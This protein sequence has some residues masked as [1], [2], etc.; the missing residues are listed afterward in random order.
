MPDLDLPEALEL[1]L[2]T[3]EPYWYFLGGRPSI[4]LVNTFRER[5]R[6]RVE[7]LVTPG[8]LAAWLRRAGLL[9]PAATPPRGPRGHA[10]LADARA[11]REAVDAGVVA[12]VEGVAPPAAA[13]AT[14]DGWLAAADARPTLRPGPDGQPLLARTV[15]D[16]PVRA[17]LAALALDAAEALGSPAAR[18]R[19]RICA[20]ATCSARFYDRSPAGRR[21][22][23]SM[24]SCGNVAK[25]RRHR[26]R[27]APSDRGET[28]R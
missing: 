8:D 7:T 4:D 14:I 1:P 27:Q 9:D 6:R 19:V 2:A 20:G 23:C 17:A 13:L 16:D 25:A 12:A 15:P 28:E 3:G 21:R 5:W 10:A 26:A 24:A 11:L 18:A 22:W